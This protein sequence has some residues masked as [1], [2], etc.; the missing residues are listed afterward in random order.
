MTTLDDKLL[1]EK[2]QNYCSSS[3]SEEEPDNQDTRHGAKK[4]TMKFIP[5]SE[6]K[7]SEESLN[8]KGKAANTGPK[9][10][11]KDWQRFKQLENEKSAETD[12]EKARLIKKLAMTCKSGDLDELAEKHNLPKP[13]QQQQAQAEADDDLMDDEFFQE[14]I[15]KKFMEMN[16]KLNS[17]PKFGEVKEL[18]NDTFLTEIDNE[19]KNVKILI[20]IYDQKIPECRLMN[21]CLDQLSKDYV[22]VKF[23]KIRSAE[24]NLSEKFKKIGCPALL[25][26]Q[27]G[28]LI[29]NFVKM[30]DE[31]GDE[32][33]AS[34]VENFLLEQ[35][36]L[37]SLDVNTIRDGVCSKNN[38]SDDDE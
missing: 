13:A 4:D 35:G 22:V 27:N 20:H 12:A 38:L 16:K 33:C 5:E 23:C 19:N 10:V 8:W 37:P 15:K 30:N 32:F 18:T 21:E 29:G 2:L 24:I 25:I 7:E 17:L 11:I 3:E 6:I 31:F 9:G 28:E 14:Y 1:G 36:Y 34:D 26:Y